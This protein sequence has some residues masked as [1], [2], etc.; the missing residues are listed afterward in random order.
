MTL[1]IDGKPVGELS[2]AELRREADARRR[3]RRGG[4]KGGPIAAT[5]TDA[6]AP[7][8]VRKYFASLELEPGASKDEVQNRYLELL[9]RYDPDR[10]KD[11]AKKA[12]A[13]ELT[14]KLREAYEGIKA[15]VATR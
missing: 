5:P 6:P 4:M 14:R 9:D 8:Q 7:D 2:D 15:Y 10:Q 12:V 3:A 11:D 13:Q 1:R